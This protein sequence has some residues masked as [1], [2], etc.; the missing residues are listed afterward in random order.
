M[1]KRWIKL[2][3][4]IMAV[5]F[6]MT[7]FTGC[8]G[9][10]KKEETSTE[11]TTEATTKGID[12][13]G[14]VSKDLP[15]YEMY[16]KVEDSSDLPDWTGK[17]LKLKAWYAHGT[18][19]AIR[20]T[21]ENDVVTPEIKRVTGIEIDPDASFDNGGQ[22]I[23]VKLGMLA[24][25]QDWPDI[26]FVSHSGMT[27]F[28]EA[29]AAGEI[30]D[31]TEAINQF[32][33]NLLKRI[34]FDKFPEVKTFVTNYNQD[35]NIYAFPM[36]LGFPERSLKIL[37]PS[38][39]N[40]NSQDGLDGSPSILIRDDI[41]KMLYPNAKS[42]DEIEALYMEKGTFT[43]EDIYDV[44]LKSTDDMIKLL[45][46]IRDLI[47]SKNLQE[48]GKPLKVTYAFTGQD[49]W[50][51]FAQ[52]LPPLYRIPSGNNYFTYYDK[53]TKNVEFMFQQDFFKEI[54]KQ[55][56][57]FVRD[58]VMDETSLLDNNAA[59]LEKLNNGQYV[60]TICEW[61][62]ETVLKAAG[63]TFRYR[64]L[65]IDAPLQ[66]D[67]FIAP[68]SPVTAGYGIMIFKDRVKEEDLP[69]II[70]YLDYMVSEVGEKMYSWGPRSAG[71]FEEKNGKRVFKDKELEEA[72]VYAKDNGKALSYNLAN[73]RIASMGGYGNAW[74]YYPTYMWGGSDLHPVYDYE[75]ER[76]AAD[77]KN[78]F[79]PG[80]LPGNSYNE[81]GND[82]L[83]DHYI[84]SFFGIESVDKFWK[85][86]D[87][88]EKALTKTLAAQN[89]D[90]FEK[91]WKEFSDLAV[92]VGATPEMLKDINDVFKKANEGYL[93]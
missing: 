8:G 46:D 49:N 79:N 2:L 34:P 91:L 21:S 66:T 50:R 65:W 16:D 39:V 13:T 24:A 64:P 86:R 11:A 36:Q 77:G 4:L 92:K 27:N 20:N 78:F 82:L 23:D 87:A 81:L 9:S 74:P 10:D 58:G 35:G 44:P 60:V 29:I 18:G 80:N 57:K 70:R 48:N 71:L 56:N 47:K 28:S 22:T 75:K 90:E 69:Q 84:W 51:V 53:T 61:P 26:A 5:S 17:Q 52:L 15:Y 32:A 89:D 62:D 73:N 59:F 42:A 76:N 55:F 93:D 31:L 25:A 68:L 37:N 41:L 72:M 85:G 38:F 54:A 83:K 45:Y 43:K 14:E 88:F 6:V 19:D 33:P 30:Y 7:L 12:S 40:P 67:R 63:K 1:R 3:A